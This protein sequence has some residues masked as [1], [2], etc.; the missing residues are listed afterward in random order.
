MS[1]VSH[2]VLGGVALAVLA[3][4]NFCLSFV[5][6]GDHAA[7]GVAFGLLTLQAVVVGLVFLELGRESSSFKLALLVA[8]FLVLLLL[9]FVESDVRFRGTPPLPPPRTVPAHAI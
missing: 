1:G 9:G 7:L 4:L 3:A 6:M 8:A 5:A 2:K